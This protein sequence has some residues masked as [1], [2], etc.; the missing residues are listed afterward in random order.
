MELNPE[1]LD[2]VNTL[3]GPLLVIAGAGS[4]KTRVV[5]CRIVHLLEQ[6][7]PPSKI[8]GLTFT[9]KAAE[10]MRERVRRATRQHVLI[11]TFHSLGLRML[12][13]SIDRLGYPTDFTIYDTD[14]VEKLIKICLQELGD[15][16]NKKI[17]AKSFREAISRAKNDLL[18]PDDVVYSAG[19][20]PFFQLFPSVFKLYQAK[21]KEYKALDFDDLLLLPVRLLREHPDLLA[22]YQQRWHYLL[23]DEYQ[24][25]NAAQ[26]TLVNLLAS[27]HHNLCVVGDPDQSIYSWRGANIRN[28]L[29]FQRDY[30]NARVIRLEQNYRSQSNILDAANALISHN[31]NRFEKQLWSTIGAGDKI[32]LFIAND[33]QEEANF[34]ISTLRKHANAGLKLEDMVIFYRT[35]AQ[36]RLFEDALL[37]ARIPYRIVGSLSFYQRREIKDILA[38]LRVAHS[39]ADFISF[40]RTINLPKRGLGDATIEK[41]RLYAFERGEPILRICQEL[42]EPNTKLP[43][44]LN[45]RQLLGLK[46]YLKGIMAIREKAAKNDSLAHV[47]QTAMEETGYLNY[48]QEEKETAQERRENLDALITK[49]IEWEK[50]TGSSTLAGFLE[51]LTL[52]TNNEESDSTIECVTLMTLHNSKGLEF[53]V[54]LLVGMEEELL[55]HTNARGSNENL[56][57]ERRLCYVGFTRAQ[58]S[59]YLT[60]SR[61]RYLWGTLRT[62]RPSRFLQEIPAQ[63]VEKVF[64]QKRV[65]NNPP[66]KSP[67]SFAP[68]SVSLPPVSSQ[69]CLFHE[70][71]IVRHPTFGPG[72]IRKVAQ[73]SLGTTYTISFLDDDSDKQIVAKYG[74]LKLIERANHSS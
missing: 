13:E 62:Q 2:A 12:R 21:L 73:G 61:T 63:Y 65:F 68:P 19:N 1:Q 8:L 16:A 51:E 60:S 28:I 25:T 22:Y 11:S 17:D 34:V 49:A 26:Y 4:G 39:D 70:G 36:S 47:V 67:T 3:E 5:T 9:N 69:E 41:I 24:D 33:E 43:I 52:K 42:I 46:S 56:E 71:D 53:P 14:D 58:Q 15:V 18:S 54:V 27:A 72:I 7:V 74:H 35:N 31:S 10:E 45:E 20:D 40:T 29:E 32:Q 55:P 57:E 37:S 48:L 38:F 30:P 64:P 23:I 66:L 50:R 6:G 44:R 59:L